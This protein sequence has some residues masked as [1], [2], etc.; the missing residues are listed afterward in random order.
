MGSC[1]GAEVPERDPQA[2]LADGDAFFHEG[3]VGRQPALLDEAALGVG[4]VRAVFAEVVGLLE[5][6]EEDVDLHIK[7]NE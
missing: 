2:L 5:S 3:R 4:G 1:V 6:E 7:A